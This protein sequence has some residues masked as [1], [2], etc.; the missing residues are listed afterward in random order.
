MQNAATSAPPGARARS[1]SFRTAF[2]TAYAHRVAERLA[3]IN[4]YV[5][6][7]VEA[8]TGRSIL[9]VL[10]ETFGPAEAQHLGSVTGRLIGMQYHA[11]TAECL[12]IAG[13]SAEDFAELLRRMGEAQDDRIAWPREGDEVVVRQ[14]TWR[15]TKGIAALPENPQ[16]KL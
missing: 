11:E 14:H 2:L 7:D 15:L 4:A 5:V 1:R 3:E 12:G 13:H 10:A 16:S 6:A 9:P 8:E